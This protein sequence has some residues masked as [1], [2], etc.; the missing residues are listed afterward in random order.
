MRIMAIDYGDSRT[1]AAVSDESATL[2]GDVWVVHSKRDTDKALALSDEAKKRGVARIVVGYPKNMDG[3][4]GPRAKK[5]EQFADLLRSFTDIEVTVWDERLTTVS[6][7]RLLD[8]AKKYGKKRKKTIDAVAAS[9]ILESY[10]RSM[11]K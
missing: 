8:D 3:S 2:V 6:A 4:I 10:L 1:G 11:K 9:L 7:H 5:S